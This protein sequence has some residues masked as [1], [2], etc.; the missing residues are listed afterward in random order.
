MKKFEIIFENMEAQLPKVEWISKFGDLVKSFVK[1]E[2]Q[3][4]LKN[5]QIKGTPEQIES[6]YSALKQERKFFLIAQKEGALSRDLM[7]QEV[8]T[9][10]AVKKF[11]NL[12]KI[13]W[14]VR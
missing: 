9:K 4:V 11:E 8:I 12:T 6:F 2:S 5:A 3:D 13:P 14:P 1:G 10:N 7:Q